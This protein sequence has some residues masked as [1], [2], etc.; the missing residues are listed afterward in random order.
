[1]SELIERLTASLASREDVVAAWLFGSRARG[2]AN[3][4]SDADVAVLLATNPLPTL[5]KY[6]FELATDL[7]VRAG[8][9][10]DLVVVNDA[11]ADLVHRVLRDGIIL[12]DRDRSRRIA[13]EVKKRAEYLDMA[14]IWRAYRRQPQR[15]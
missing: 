6:A 5:D 14:P 3:D 9:H 7:T 10:V 13:F 2:S 11:S 15:A 4:R 8:T 1:V 12:L